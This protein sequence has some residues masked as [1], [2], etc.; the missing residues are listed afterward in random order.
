MGDWL[1]VYN[2]ADVVHLLR[3]LERWPGNIIL[4][5]LMY[6]KTQYINDIRAEQVLGKK[7]KL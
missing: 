7:Q 3:P 1:R 2:V 5:K 6:A 4:I